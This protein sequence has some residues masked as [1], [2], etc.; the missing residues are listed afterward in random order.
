MGPGQAAGGVGHLVGQQATQCL[1]P[2]PLPASNRNVTGSAT[3]SGSGA[4]AACPRARTRRS[5][6]TGS[7]RSARNPTPACNVQPR[8]TCSTLGTVT[9][10][11]GSSRSAV[12]GRATRRLEPW[13]SGRVRHDEGSS[14]PAGG[15]SSGRAAVTSA[16]LQANATD[17]PD[18]LLTSSTSEPPASVTA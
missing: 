6:S 16:R 4:S 18:R 14:P 5:S 2:G 17:V 8:T 15:S 11:S 7:G 12:N 1:A 9:S 10:V 13:A 3:G